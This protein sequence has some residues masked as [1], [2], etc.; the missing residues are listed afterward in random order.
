MRARLATHCAA[1][2]SRPVV[3]AAALATGEWNQAYA[4]LE[5]ERGF[6]SLGGAEKY[7]PQLVQRKA[8]ESPAAAARV[9]LRGAEMLWRL[10]VFVCSLLADNASGRSEEVDRVRLRAQQL[11]ETLT[12]LG[13]SFV[14]AGQVLASRPD[15]VREDYMNELCTLQDDVPSYPDAEAFQIMEAELGR[16][17]AEVF[18]SI[19]ERPIAAASLGQVYKAV[20]RDTGEEVAVK[21]QRP[22]V[23]PVILRDLFIFRSMARFVNPICKVRLGCNSEL[24]L[25]E[26]GEKLLEE[27]DYQQEARNI[28]DF[29]RNFANDATVKIP[30]V[31]PDLCGPRVLV[32]EWIDGIRCTNPAAIRTSGLDVSQFIRCGVVSGLRQ[33]LEYGLFHGDPHPGNIFA[34][35]DGRIA[36]VDFGNVA[37]L[38][39]SNKQTLIDAVV[40]AVNED[41]YEMASDFIKLGFL[42][43]GT[44]IRPIV[45]ALEKIWSDSLG[46]GVADFN[47]RSVTSKFNELV[48]QYPIRIPERYALVIRSLLTQEGI[49]LTLQPDFHF[50]EVA[51]P[52]VARR[53]LTDEDPALRER[54]FQVLFQDGKF[55]WKRLENLLSLAQQGGSGGGGLDLSDTVASGARVV[56]ADNR[57]RTQLLMALTEDNRLHID[58][59][60][61]IASMVQGGIDPQRLLADSLAALPAISRQAL[62]GWSERVLAS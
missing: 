8:L 48:F 36:Y 15:I 22:N 46:K 37:E 55:Q 38:S 42:A 16:P 59:V 18:S 35:R 53:L 11:R 32:M 62:M 27:L 5:M 43:P 12:V 60:A 45:P 25:D 58:E 41:Y 20:L 17:I 34:L 28:Q 52:Y 19:S 4:Q 29:G 6:C 44:D 30:W 1:S 56:L 26:F 21:V 61:R 49:C 13:P 50:L 33:L 31:R 14:K 3:S 54:L 7:S 10:G 57:M 40:H 2:T 23:G 9:V 47:F 39:Q 24:I 51:Y